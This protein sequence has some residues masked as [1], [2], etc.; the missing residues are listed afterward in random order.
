M[1]SFHLNHTCSN[2]GTFPILILGCGS[3]CIVSLH[4]SC[5]LSMPVCRILRDVFQTAAMRS[6]IFAL[7][8]LVF[9]RISH[10]LT[11]ET[12]KWRKPW[13]LSKFSM[14]IMSCAGGYLSLLS[15]LWLHQVWESIV[16]VKLWSNVGALK[17]FAVISTKTVTV[18]QAPQSGKQ[19]N[20]GMD[21]NPCNLAQFMSTFRRVPTVIVPRGTGKHIVQGFGITTGETGLYSQQ[22][23]KPALFCGL[24][25][26][27][28][29]LTWMR[30]N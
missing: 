3:I 23:S 11:S 6:T 19:R 7:I 29:D 20:D 10:D 25:F 2:K 1:R 8:P 9:R 5:F 4:A 22:G 16:S 26:L 14:T 27:W 21:N 13:N 28:R 18:T 30:P 17:I 15:R 24:A 12:R